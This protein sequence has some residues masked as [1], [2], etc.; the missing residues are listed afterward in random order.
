MEFDVF[1]F[2]Y[3]Q[4]WDIDVEEKLRVRITSSGVSIEHVDHLIDDQ[5]DE[6]YEFLE[7]T[8]KP[9]LEKL[10]RRICPVCGKRM[11]KVSENRSVWPSETGAFLRS[12]GYKDVSSQEKQEETFYEC[13]CGVTLKKFERTIDGGAS[14]QLSY[15]LTRNGKTAEYKLWEG[16]KTE[17][18]FLMADLEFLDGLIKTGIIQIQEADG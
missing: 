17:K 7:K 8:S 16:M 14:Y 3:D 4:G 11:R 1:L 13:R 6:L 9:V 12:R 2:Y 15:Q 10:R 5:K 18:T